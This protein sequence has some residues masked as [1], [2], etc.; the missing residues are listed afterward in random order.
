MTREETNRPHRRRFD[1]LRVHK[2]VDREVRHLKGPG[3]KISENKRTSAYHFL[4]LCHPEGFKVV[5]FGLSQKI[6][7]FLGGVL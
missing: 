6:C 3:E 4:D 1:S 5:F 7:N 2:E